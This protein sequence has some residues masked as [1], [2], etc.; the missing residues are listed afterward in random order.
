VRLALPAG[1]SQ[2]EVLPARPIALDAARLVET[3]RVD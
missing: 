3:D 2:V 1:F